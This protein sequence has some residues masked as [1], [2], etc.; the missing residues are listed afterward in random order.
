MDMGIAQF[1]SEGSGGEENVQ[2]SP[3]YMSPE[4]VCASH[5]TWSSDLYS[6]GAT[7]YHM[8][9]GRPIFDDPDVQQI[10]RMQAYAPFPDPNSVTSY[11]KISQP[12]VELLR[13][14]LEK[15][16]SDRFDSWMGFIEAVDDAIEKLDNASSIKG[17]SPDSNEPVPA[18]KTKQKKKHTQK[19]RHVSRSTYT[20]IKKPIARRSTS[21]NGF[22]LVVLVGLLLFAAVVYYLYNEHRNNAIMAYNRA[23]LI[24]GSGQSYDEKISVFRDALNACRGTE[25]EQEI[26][27]TYN[28]LQKEKELQKKAAENYKKAKEQAVNLAADGKYKEAIYL[29]QKAGAELTDPVLRKDLQSYLKTLQDGLRKK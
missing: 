13:T 28:E 6:L 19:T 9:V 26:L 15:K 7:L 16:P 1:M 3:Y 24:Y 14:A 27:M 12:T 11:Y 8:V 20:G 22:M 10:I 4:Q 5:L 2:G 23:K 18:K 25:M 21:G 17:K 29:I